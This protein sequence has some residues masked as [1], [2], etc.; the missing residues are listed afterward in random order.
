MSHIAWLESLAAKADYDIEINDILKTQPSDI[1]DAYYSNNQ[2]GLK[3][4]LGAESRL[5]DKNTIFHC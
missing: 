2:A 4:L 3:A 5:A 1:Q